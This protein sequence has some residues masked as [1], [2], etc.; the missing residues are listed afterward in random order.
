MKMMTKFE[1][2]QAKFPQHFATYIFK[3]SKI[4]K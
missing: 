3:K 1:D 4:Y 2:T